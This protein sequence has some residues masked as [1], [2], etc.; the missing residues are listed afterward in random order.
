MHQLHPMA[1]YFVYSGSTMNF[2]RHMHG[3]RCDAAVIHD[4][5]IGDL[6]AGEIRD[7]DCADVRAGIATERE[8][9]CETGRGGHG[10]ND[11]DLIRVGEMVMAIPVAFPIKSDWELVQS[12]SWAVTQARNSGQWEV[13][14]KANEHLQTEP[15]CSTAVSYTHLTLPT[16]CSV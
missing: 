7:K 12:L 3:G 15:Q 2:A 9:H 8:A 10:R 13:A 5:R 1:K 11:C 6:H 4:K 14:V 16:I